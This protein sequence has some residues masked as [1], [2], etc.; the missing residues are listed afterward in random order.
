MSTKMAKT[1]QLSGKDLKQPSSQSLPPSHEMHPKDM[2]SSPIGS[3][4]NMFPRHGPQ[5]Q[6]HI[7][8]EEL[9]R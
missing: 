6:Q 3:Y 1:E 2:N 8:D 4:S 5:S 9:R 7:R